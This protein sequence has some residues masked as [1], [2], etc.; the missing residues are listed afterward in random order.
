MNLTEK[1]A[2]ITGGG[3]GIGFGIAETL[4]EKGTNLVL[5]QPILDVAKRAASR[6]KRVE[7]L[8][9]E[10]DIRDL[11][12]VEAMVESTVGHFGR[13][14]ILVNNAAIT[15]MPALIPMLECRTSQV[16]EIVDV[17][18]KG[19]FY[20]SKTVAKS[21]VSLGRGGSIVHIASVGAYAAQHFATLYCATKAAQVSMAQSMALE[22]APHNIRVNCVAPG[23]ILTETS[24]NTGKQMHE[25]GVLERYVRKTP[26]G[27]P[28][29]PRDIGNAVAFLVSEEATFVTGTTLTVDGGFLSY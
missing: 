9:L 24:A 10:A 7:V 11:E 5:V 13:V 8:A 17:N 28:G 14:D 19:T 26:L 20:C 1:V 2:I 12:A 29:S 21:M 27:H 18:L 15:G 22:L 16:D 25:V 3:T 6:L 23:E 4:A